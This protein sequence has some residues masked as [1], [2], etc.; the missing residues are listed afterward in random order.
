[1]LHQL[2]A[3]LRAALALTLL[4]LNTLFWVPILLLLALLKLMLV[5]QSVRLYLD[6]WLIR[7]AECWISGNSTWMKLT[8]KLN[9]DVQGLEA[10]QGRHWYLVICNH[11]S[12]VDIFVLQ[13]VLNRRIA[14]LKFFLKH[15]LIWIPV[16]GLAWWALDFPFMRRYSPAY[17]ARHPSA[18][19]KDI[20]AARAACE[21]FALVPTSVMNFV[22]GTRWTAH[23]HRQQT[24]PY[25]HLLRPKAGGFTLALQAMGE[26]F[27]AVLDIT[28]CYP[29]GRPDFWQ[30]LKG[31]LGHVIVRMH[32]LPVP[33]VTAGETEQS[34]PAFRSACEAWLNHR[35][36]LKDREIETL[37]EDAKSARGAVKS[38]ELSSR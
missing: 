15:Q 27:T 4:T 33:H 38:H 28:I 5:L 23:K 14:L 9:W 12:W 1:M 36:Q 11:Q 30:F 10:L 22:E 24:S 3:P 21:K 19:G 8:Q 35:W 13:H 7:I 6:P 18:R 32:V 2:P 29:G 37:M 17:L 34:G 26:R 20:A 16:M 31:Q 25:R